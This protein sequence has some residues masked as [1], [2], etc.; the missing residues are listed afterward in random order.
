MAY[1]SVFMA[2][3]KLNFMALNF[4]GFAFIKL[5]L[6]CFEKAENH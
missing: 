6:N 5:I 3:C 2:Y 1:C 4:L